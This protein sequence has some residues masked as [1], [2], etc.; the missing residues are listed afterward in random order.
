MK[1]IKLDYIKQ[2][3]IW[4]RCCCFSFMSNRSS[5]HLGHELPFTL[6]FMLP[7]YYAAGIMAWEMKVVVFPFRLNR[8][9][10]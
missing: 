9:L 4:F 2:H 7:Y 8:F 6:C 3:V 1:E 10:D 5:D